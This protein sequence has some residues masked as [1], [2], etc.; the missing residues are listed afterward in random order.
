MNSLIAKIV[1]RSA[2][3]FL[4]IFSPALRFIE[5]KTF[6]INGDF[7]YAPIFI[8]GAPR[9]GSTILYQALT[10]AYQFAYIDNT[11]CTWHRNLRFG[12]WLSHKI[13]GYKPHNNFKAEHGNTRKF[14]GHAPSECGKFWYRWLPKDRHFIDHNEVTPKMLAEIREEVLGAS[15]YL[16]RP[17]L[18]KNLNT[19]QRLRLIHRAFP[20]AKIIFVRRDPRYVTRSIL[21]ARRKVGTAGGQ[22]WSIMP[23]NVEALRK[24]P[25]GEMCAAQA[26]YLERQIE[27]DLTLF[28]KENLQEIHYQDFDQEL[29]RC[30]GGWAG[31]Q[32]RVGASMPEFQHDNP[33]LLSQVEHEELNRLVEKYPFKKELFV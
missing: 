15:A 10:N 13:Y 31:V 28:P 33:D 16:Q 8:I 23:P 1:R 6:R 20:D 11:A 12:L 9:T 7:S 5:K 30:L 24:L 29:I 2:N 21:K 3:R 25:E 22:W 32:R 26:Y 27:E 19:G 4:T 18:F 17:I 14:G